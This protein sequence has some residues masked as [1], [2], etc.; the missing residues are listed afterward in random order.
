MAS[1]AGGPHTDDPLIDELLALDLLTQHADT[2]ATG[3]GLGPVALRARLA[4]ALPQS[5]LCVVRRDARVVAYGMITTLSPTK[6]QV[7]AFTVHPRFR[8]PRVM[9]ELLAGMAELID[10][11][12]LDE[13]CCHVHKTNRASV[14]FHR[15]LGF[16]VR[17]ESDKAYEFVAP[18]AY[19]LHS[20]RAQRLLGGAAPH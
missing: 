6:W 11:L 2:G 17:E 1:A 8:L 14:R 19:L 7:S 5:R 18:T 12:Q 10:A 3:D 20:P 16:A 4:E 9:R 15:A 13:L